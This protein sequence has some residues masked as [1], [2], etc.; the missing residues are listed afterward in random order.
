MP[1][2][3][4][5][6]NTLNDESWDILERLASGEVRRSI[7]TIDLVTDHLGSL[8]GE[9]QELFRRILKKDLRAGF[10]TAIVNKASKKINGSALITDFPYMRCS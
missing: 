6:Y 9:S 8:T 10:G 2:V 4:P 3:T 5:G 7:D 1:A